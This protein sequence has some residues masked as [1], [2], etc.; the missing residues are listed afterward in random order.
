MKKETEI[1][2]TVDDTDG[3]CKTHFN[4]GII[5]KVGD[6]MEDYFNR[7]TVEKVLFKINGGHNGSSYCNSC[8]LICNVVTA[9]YKRMTISDK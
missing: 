1:N 8:T 6:V 7:Y 3:N 2:Y 9:K 5:F 4:S